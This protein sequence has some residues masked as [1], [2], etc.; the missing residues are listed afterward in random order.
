MKISR[1]I[2]WLLF[3]VLHSSY[4]H[5][6]L[7]NWLGGA[8]RYNPE[9][10]S[11]LSDESK[12]LVQSAFEGIPEG[13]YHDYHAHIVGMGT[14][15]TGTWLNPKLTSW[16]H[17][18]HKFKTSIYLSGSDVSD[19]KQ[20]DEQYVA[21]FL[22]LTSNFGG[23]AKFHLLA[24]DYNYNEDGSVNKDKSEFYTPNDYVVKLAQ[25]H[26]D[27]FIPTIS[28][29]PY[30]EDWK[31]ELEKWSAEGVRYIKWLPNAQSIDPQNPR[32]DEYYQFLK[33]HDMVLLTHVGEE[34]A[35]EAE[36]DQKLGNPLRFRRALDIGVKVI[37]AH[38]GSLGENEDFDNPGKTDSNFNLFWRMMN[39]KKYEGLLFGELSAMTQSNRVPDPITTILAHPEMHHRLVNGSD[40]PLPSIN[41]V[42]STGKLV[43]AGLLSK[44]DQKHL[45]EIYQYNPLLFDFVLKRSLKHP[46]TGAKLSPSVFQ[47][48]DAL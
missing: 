36:E 13:Q 25:Q 2:P 24:F 16:R 32:L 11:Q 44:K 5:G 34:K 4:S 3:L 22:T 6:F 39:N 26:P 7:I 28:V 46:D 15:G 31:A 48:N 23:K 43:K 21:R 8:S 27:L 40:Y 9:D 1:I 18:I 33:Q 42:I 17:P 30:R 38:C 41:A 45:K 20:A 14:G 29:H 12:A 47:I 35:V 10:I 19:N 37:M